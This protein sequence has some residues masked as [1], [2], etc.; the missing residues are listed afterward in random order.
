[1]SMGMGVVEL[2]T[3]GK[4]PKRKLHQPPVEYGGWS[5]F[6]GEIVDSFSPT[7]NDTILY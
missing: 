7:V 4:L 6:M 5:K 3:R 2:T 1:M